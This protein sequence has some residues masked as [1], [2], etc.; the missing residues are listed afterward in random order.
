MNLNIVRHSSQKKLHSDT[1]I[2][3]VD[4]FGESSNFYNLTSITFMGGSIVKHGGQNPLEAARLGN[5][6]FNGPNID[7]FKEI[8]LYLKKNNISFTT[9]NFSKMRKIILKN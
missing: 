2:Y 8:Y 3:I 6:I 5:H 7:N 1:D 4:A 9:S